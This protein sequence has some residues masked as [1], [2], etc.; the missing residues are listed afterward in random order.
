MK[1][2]LSLVLVLL[3]FSEIHSQE[4]RGEMALPVISET[5]FYR[6]NLT[7]AQR[8]FFTSDFS[9]LRITDQ[10]N[11]AVPYL[12][13]T[14]H[15]YQV[16]EFIEHRVIG[17]E[18]VKN[19]CTTI[20][21]EN[22][23][24]TSL[25]NL[26]VRIRNAEVNK[27]GTLRGSD[28]QITWYALKETFY[29][30]NIAGSEATSEL[31]IIGFPLT[32]YQYL[33]LWINDSV[34]APLNIMSIGYYKIFETS[35]HYQDILR[36]GNKVSH[37]KR[38]T[39]INLSFDTLQYIDRL[40]IRLSGAPM[41]SRT[42]TVYQV[43]EKMSKTGKLEKYRRMLIQT[44]L[45]HESEGNLDIEGIQAKNI[46]V[47]IENGDNP[48]L[49]LE[50]IMASQRSHYVIAYLEK[51]KAYTLKIGG[52]QMLSPDYDLSYFRNLI[53]ADKLPIHAGKI[54]IYEDSSMKS[55]EEPWINRNYMWIGI[56]A[57]IILLGLMSFRM[58]REAKLREE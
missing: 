46:Q 38:K 22:K 14:E 45:T 27:Q 47:E 34:T 26:H 52:E 16:N 17:N 44:R 42:A 18:Q 50:A 6:I 29:L 25:S 31:R 28:D 58:I 30:G 13:E 49:K 33:Q 24:K 9:N 20:T 5:G 53:D 57:I 10:Q 4:F 7:S 54:N 39:Y 40:H 8:N 19:C 23:D 55:K 1:Y 2:I 3:C 15:D 12:T 21:L 32:N 37:D 35:S 43:S 36:M 48:P 51:E 41:Y 11:N 56:I